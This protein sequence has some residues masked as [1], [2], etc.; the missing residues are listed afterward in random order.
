MKKLLLILFLFSSPFLCLGQKTADVLATLPKDEFQIREIANDLYQKQDYDQAIQVFLKGRKL[1]SDEQLFTFELISL[2]RFKRDKINLVPEYLN[3]LQTAPQLLNQAE[4]VFSTIFENNADYYL[5]QTALL[6]KMQKEPDNEVYAKLLTWQYLQTRAYN[7]ALKQLIAQ[8]KRM[9]DDGGLLFNYIQIFIS[10]K[11]Y[12]EAAAAY[13]YLLSKGTTN[14]YYLPAKLGLTDV[15]YQMMLSNPVNT[16][17]AAAALLAEYQALLKEYGKNVNTVYAMRRIAL[18]EAQ[19]LH[20]P[21]KAAAILDEVLS[22]SNLPARQ[23]AEIKLELGDIYVNTGKPW[24]AIL[25]YG[26]VAKEFEGQDIS[27]EAQ[28]RSARLS[29]YQGNFSYAKSQADVLKASTTQLVANDALNLSLMLSDHLQSPEDSLALSL[30]AAADLMQFNNQYPAALKKLDSISVKYPNNTLHDD[31]LML[32]AQILI[33]GKDFAAAALLLQQ[34]ISNPQ[35][36]I[37][38]DDAIFSLA[39]LY[40]EQLAKPEEAKMLYQKLI[41]DFPGSMHT[42]EARRHF[43]KL[44]GDNI[45]S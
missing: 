35:S 2:Y 3:A 26:Q 4:N 31:V 19:Y 24:E 34:L 10:N 33:K 36:D 29:F 11:A 9:K 1:L 40:E 42:A 7:M 15:K 45:E 13:T 43:R 20:H 41:T 18:L 17:G 25:L 5:L 22:I 38:T 23:S 44:R 8:D 14:E 32:K 21:E 6:K 39:G 37:W 30:Y 28:Y 27:N 16:P 12:T